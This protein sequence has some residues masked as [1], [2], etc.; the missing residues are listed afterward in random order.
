MSKV[1]KQFNTP[2]HVVLVLS[3]IPDG[4]RNKARINNKIVKLVPVCDLGP[5][6]AFKNDNSKIDYVGAEV[7]PA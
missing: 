3:Y 4:L 2:E 7:F 1:I 5:T 6:I